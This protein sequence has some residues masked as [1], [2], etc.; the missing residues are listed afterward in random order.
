MSK[1]RV[2]VD[3]NIFLNAWFSS[4]HFYCDAVIDLVDK[5]NI[6]LVFSQDTIGELFYLLK[7]FVSHTS[8]DKETKYEYMHILSEIF[9][10]A[11][12][13]NTSKTKCPELFDVTDE[14]FL[15][16]AIESKADYIISDDFRSGMHNVKLEGT[17]IV[18][19]EEFV[20]IYERLCG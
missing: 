1:I 19:S 4:N 8:Y 5:K 3:T 10:D 15:Q 7:N 20:S 2:V 14:M 11:F 13:T 16:T 12:S 6:Q 18:S 9:F 17:K